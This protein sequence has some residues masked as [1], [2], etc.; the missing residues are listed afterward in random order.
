MENWK[1]HQIG[2]IISRNHL[3]QR[4]SEAGSDP[5]QPSKARILNAHTEDLSRIKS[6]K[7]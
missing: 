2:K 4:V 1:F 5:N 7:L 3:R 6:E